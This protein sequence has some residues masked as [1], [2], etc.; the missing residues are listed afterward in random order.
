MFIILKYRDNDALYIMCHISVAFNIIQSY[1]VWIMQY[2]NL[3][4]KRIQKF[5]ECSQISTNALDR[6]SGVFIDCVEA[7]NLILLLYYRRRKKCRLM[8]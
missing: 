7:L 4:E 2:V 5:G 6:L 1:G 8:L 3:P